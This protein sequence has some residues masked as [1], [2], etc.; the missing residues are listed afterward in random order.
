MPTGVGYQDAPTWA[1]TSRSARRT[2]PHDRAP[3]PLLFH[4]LARGERDWTELSDEFVASA[5]GNG[6][7]HEAAEAVFQRLLRDALWTFD[8]RDVIERDARLVAETAYL[9]AHHPAEFVVALAL[10]PNAGA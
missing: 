4:E 8:E 9:K 6:H 10:V 2:R 1:S 5:T 3:D 7:A